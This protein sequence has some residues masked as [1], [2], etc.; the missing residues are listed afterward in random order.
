MLVIMPILLTMII[1]MYTTCSTIMSN[2][3]DLAK[4]P[5]VHLKLLLEEQWQCNKTEIPYSGYFSWGK[6]F[7]VFV[8]E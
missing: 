2:K 5:A 1:L 4:G 3:M 8:V 7:V 6:K